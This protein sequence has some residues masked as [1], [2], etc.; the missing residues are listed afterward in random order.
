MDSDLRNVPRMLFKLS[1]TAQ[2]V[3]LSV[4]WSLGANYQSEMRLIIETNTTVVKVR[5]TLD[6]TW[7][8]VP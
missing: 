3:T 6:K 7:V 8:D 2:K 4:P 1:R 5:N